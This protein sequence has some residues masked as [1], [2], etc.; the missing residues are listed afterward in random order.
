MSAENPPV[1]KSITEP[2]LPDDWAF[3]KKWVL[4]N[5]IG[6]VVAVLGGMTVSEAAS[7][8][9]PIIGSVTLTR[10]LELVGRFG[11]GFVLG[12]LLGISQWL[13]LRRRLS[14]VGWWVVATAVGWLVGFMAWQLS[15][16][17]TITFDQEY[18]L[19]LVLA[20]GLTGTLTGAVLGILQALTLRF[21]VFHAGLWVL[22]SIVGWS[23]AVSVGQAMFSDLTG[24]SPPELMPLR[25]CGLALAGTIYAVLTGLP[26]ARLLRHPLPAAPPAAQDTPP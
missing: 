25:G 8:A 15:I 21:Q 17:Y 10:I 19:D 7:R 26:L 12:V 11:F 4:A 20:C 24:T 13:V 16:R 3:W 2:T 9:T 23:I 5:T 6:W 18:D 22:A 1:T 14:N